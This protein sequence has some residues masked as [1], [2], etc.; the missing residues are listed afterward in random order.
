MIGSSLLRKFIPVLAL[1]KN[2]CRHQSYAPHFVSL[3]TA[4][5]LS[6]Q[7]SPTFGNSIFTNPLSLEYFAKYGN[8]DLHVCQSP[9]LKLETQ[10][11]V[12]VILFNS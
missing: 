7:P 2:L 6:K 11:S 8:Q 4:K 10:L 12:T 3:A 5:Y 9:S 1:P